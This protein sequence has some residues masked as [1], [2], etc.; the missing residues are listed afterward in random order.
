[1]SK[2]EDKKDYYKFLDDYYK[3]LAAMSDEERLRFDKETDEMIEEDYN[4]ND[5]EFREKIIKS[6]KEAEA[7]YNETMLIEKMLKKYY[8]KKKSV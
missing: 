3:D 8:T 4:S 2:K 6:L 7:N 5:T 1:M